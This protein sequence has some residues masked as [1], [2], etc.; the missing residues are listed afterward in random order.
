MFQELIKEKDHDV[1]KHLTF[2]DTEQSFE[3][4]KTLKLKLHFSENE[5][6]ED[7]IIETTIEYDKN[8][9]SQVSKIIGHEIH[10]KEG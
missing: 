5:F 10:W 8:E 6:F 1:L 4:H 9:D 2:I 3:P 7:K